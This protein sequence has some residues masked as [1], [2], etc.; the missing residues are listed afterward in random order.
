M[1]IHQMDQKSFKF[2]SGYLSTGNTKRCAQKVVGQYSPQVAYN[3]E[4][5]KYPKYPQN[6]NWFNNSG[7]ITIKYYELLTFT[8]QENI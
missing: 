5:L 3:C 7:Y 8:L 4:K 1:K 2:N 6:R